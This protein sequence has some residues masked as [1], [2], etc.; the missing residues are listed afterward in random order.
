MLRKEKKS[1]K[2]KCSESHDPSFYFVPFSAHRKRT[3][4]V[5]IMWPWNDEERRRGWNTGFVAFM[6][7]ADAERAV[8]QLQGAVLHEREL[9][10]AWSKARTV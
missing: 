6:T 8:L 4:L 9:K 2:E 1:N 3:I 5:Q 10:I 7:R